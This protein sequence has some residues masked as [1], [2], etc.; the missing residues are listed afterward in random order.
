MRNAFSEQI[1]SLQRRAELIAMNDN[2]PQARGKL[3][4]GPELHRQPMAVLYAFGAFLK[5]IGLLLLSR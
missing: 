4:P 3:Q 2:R 5:L 1:Q